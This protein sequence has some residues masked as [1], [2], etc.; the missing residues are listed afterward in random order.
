M[1]IDNDIT[2]DPIN[3]IKLLISEKPIV[4]GAYP[5]K[6]YNW[7]NL[8]TQQLNNWMLRKENSEMKQFIDNK[9][10]I[11]HNLLQYNTH[12]CKGNNSINNN[13]IEVE[14]VATGFMMIKRDVI[15]NMQKEYSSTKYKEDEQLLNNNENKYSYALFDCGVV[16]GKYL[17]ED[18][19][20]CHRWKKMGGSLWV[21][22]SINLTHTGIED[23]QGSLLSSLL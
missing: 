6:K 2:W 14:N 23:F 21:D 4:G 3:I 9:N 8:N 11:Q 7:E 18:W 10:F 22:I 20:F 15:E 5:L 1:F 16:D 12:F 19:L 13:L 17:S